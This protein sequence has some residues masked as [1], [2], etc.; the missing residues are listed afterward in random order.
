MEEALAGNANEY[1]RAFVVTDKGMMRSGL[2]QRVLACLRGEGLDVEAFSDVYPDPDMDTIRKGVN[3]CNSFKPDLIVCLGGGSP[4]DAGKFIRAKYECP[5][6][7]LE[8]ASARFVEIRKRTC[9]FPSSWTKVKKL[10]AIPTTSGTGSEVSPFTVITS[11]E[12]DKYPIASYKLT[13]DV[14]ICDSTLCDSL[15]KKLVAHAG[16]DAITHAVESYVSVAQNDFTKMQSLEALSLLF[17]NLSERLV[18][19]FILF[20]YYHPTQK[21]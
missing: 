13:P 16:L 7:T 6:L 5:D 15:P 12:G 18:P 1:K 19:L 3:A 14:A 4:I 20:E 11:D 10:I 21:V 8:D 17:G 9:P 2:I